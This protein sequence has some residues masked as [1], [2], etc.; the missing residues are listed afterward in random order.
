MS[1]MGRFLG[2]VTC[3]L[4]Q[5]Y[6]WASFWQR[7]EKPHADWTWTCW[8]GGG[9]KEPLPDGSR[10]LLGWHHLVQ[11]RTKAFGVPWGLPDSLG[12]LRGAVLW[13]KENLHLL[14]G[15]SMNF[16]Q[17]CYWIISCD[18]QIVLCHNTYWHCSF[19]WWFSVGPFSL[20]LFSI[21]KTGVFR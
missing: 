13:K 16:L 12:V 15:G 18:A 4:L 21:S 19:E 1:E 20:E 10:V 2:T 3:K 7:A 11:C 9:S 8:G 17:T 14:F 5:K 6:R